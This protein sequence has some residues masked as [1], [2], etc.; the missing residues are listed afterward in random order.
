VRQHNGE[1]LHLRIWYVSGMRSCRPP[2]FRERQFEPSIIVTCVRW[3]CR[4][5]P[6]QWDLEEPMAERGLAVDHTTVWR[7]VQR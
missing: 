5:S 4:S 3:Y 1:V 6:S 2:L 7:W